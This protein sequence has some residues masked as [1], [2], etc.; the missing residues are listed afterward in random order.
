MPVSTS[1][2]NCLHNTCTTTS[3]RSQFMLRQDLPVFDMDYVSESV[4][5]K[6]LT[7]VLEECFPE[8]ESLPEYQGKALFVVINCKDLCAIL[9]TQHGKLCQ[10]AECLTF[11]HMYELC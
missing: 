2:R 1:E 8:I 4:F 10:A 3:V 6:I 5:E 9:P 7:S 11:S